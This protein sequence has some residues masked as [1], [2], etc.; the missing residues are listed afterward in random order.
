MIQLVE[1]FLTP[2]PQTLLH[3]LI[4]GTLCNQELN[5]YVEYVYNNVKV[6]RWTGLFNFPL[7]LSYVSLHTLTC[8]S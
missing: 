7:K 1:Q 6:E 4:F 5:Y 8:T 3:V 2:L